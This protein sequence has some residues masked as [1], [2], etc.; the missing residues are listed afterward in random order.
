MC[1]KDC[2]THPNTPP[3]KAHTY[4]GAPGSR[5]NR[6][7]LT[8]Y[9]QCKTSQGCSGAPLSMVNILLLLFL[10]LFFACLFSTVFAFLIMSHPTLKQIDQYSVWRSVSCLSQQLIIQSKLRKLHLT[11]PHLHYCKWDI[12]TRIFSTPQIIS[13]LCKCL[14]LCSLLTNW[15]TNRSHNNKEIPSL[16]VHSSIIFCNTIY[17]DLSSVWE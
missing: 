9:K 15:P 1:I 6:R 11:K 2:D 14:F 8:D 7:S 17:K 13:K 3:W 12:Y 10:S 5:M 16:S 4:K